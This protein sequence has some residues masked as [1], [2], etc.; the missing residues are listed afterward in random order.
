MLRNYLAWDFFWINLW[1]R[2]FFEFSFLAPFDNPCHLKSGA[3]PYVTLFMFQ[4]Y[5]DDDCV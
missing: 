1:S 4:I 3:P 2:D 5:P